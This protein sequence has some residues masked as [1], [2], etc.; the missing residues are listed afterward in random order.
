MRPASPLSE[1][2]LVVMKRRERER[3]AVV[4]TTYPS[5]RAIASLGALIFL[6]PLP[7]SLISSPQPSSYATGRREHVINLCGSGNI[8]STRAEPLHHLYCSSCGQAAY[9]SVGTIDKQDV[10]VYWVGSTCN[11]IA[12]RATANFGQLNDRDSVT[13]TE[14]SVTCCSSDC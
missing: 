3:E 7:A 14:V 12:L 11:L 13:E 9:W 1:Q 4:P 6:W 8:V 5:S 10:C 2:H